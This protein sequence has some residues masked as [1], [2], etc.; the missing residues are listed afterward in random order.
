VRELLLLETVIRAHSE[1][2]V[3]DVSV[4]KVHPRHARESPLPP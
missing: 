3:L 2:I 1:R 4:W